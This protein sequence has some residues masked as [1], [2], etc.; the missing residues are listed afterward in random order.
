MHSEGVMYVVKARF[1]EIQDL[2]L[3]IK[4][5][6]LSFMDGTLFSFVFNYAFF[7]YVDK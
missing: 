2:Q 3:R 7:L 5:V 1:Q 4:Q 6:P